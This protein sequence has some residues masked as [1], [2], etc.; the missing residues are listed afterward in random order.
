MDHLLYLMFRCN[1]DVMENLEKFGETKPVF[2]SKI[3]NSNFFSAST[4]RFKSR[5]NKKHIATAVCKWQ[6][7]SNKPK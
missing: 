3:Q 5:R 1:F 6:D 4:W 2:S 7:E